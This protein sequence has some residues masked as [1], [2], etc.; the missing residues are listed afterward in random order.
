MI[1]TIIGVVSVLC[2]LIF[3]PVLSTGAAADLGDP[4]W[5]DDVEGYDKTAAAPQYTIGYCYPY[6]GDN[7][8]LKVADSHDLASREYV[9]EG[10]YSV[11]FTNVGDDALEVL[12]PM[13]LD[14]GAKL[15]YPKTY[16][17]RFLLKQIIPFGSAEDYL[18]VKASYWD[19]VDRAVDFMFTNDASGDLKVKCTKGAATY[20]KAVIQKI[21]DDLYE[22][23]IRFSAVPGIN[24]DYELVDKIQ[25]HLCGT[26]GFA[27]DDTKVYESTADPQ[28]AF[29]LVPGKTS[30]STTAA[31]TATQAP[32]GD[33][34]PTDGGNTTTKA[35]AGNTNTTTKA[36]A[37]DGAGDDADDQDAAG[38]LSA[39]ALIAL[40]VGSV[41]V[42]GAV[43]VIVVIVIR[44]KKGDI[45]E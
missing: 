17:L 4:M 22:V 8:Y 29:E 26:G 10:N 44:R 7:L 16:I 38:G 32:A 37:T 23:A 6:P 21:G 14:T 19:K 28:E 3:L 30:S 12:T 20:E 27:V 36:P 9:I 25:W 33:T 15:V 24:P 35:P 13:M 42:L 40:I 2:V 39:P 1:K 5:A 31:S 18:M 11:Y 45:A 41:V 34:T 43:A